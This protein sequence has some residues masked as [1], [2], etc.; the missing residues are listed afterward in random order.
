[1]QHAIGNNGDIRQH[2]ELQPHKKCNPGTW[3]CQI[4]QL[5]KQQIWNYHSINSK[6]HWLRRVDSWS[7]DTLKSLQEFILSHHDVMTCVWLLSSHEGLHKAGTRLKNL[8]R[9]AFCICCNMNIQFLSRPSNM[10]VLWKYIIHS[11]PGGRPVRRSH[12]HGQTWPGAWWMCYFWKVI[13]LFFNFRVIFGQACTFCS[14]DT[15]SIV[16]I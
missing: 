1:M 15:H 6:R 2:V 11:K 10:S 8:Y 12:C 13:M 5:W 4:M 16:S 7:Y 14:F 9:T 3:I